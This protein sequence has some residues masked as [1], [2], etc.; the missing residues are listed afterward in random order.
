MWHL[1]III[2]LI[3][4]KYRVTFN[5]QPFTKIY[6]CL[7]CS[8]NRLQYRAQIVRDVLMSVR[9][10]RL[11]RY[12]KQT[13][14]DLTDLAISSRKVLIKVK[15]ITHMYSAL[16]WSLCSIFVNKHYNNKDH[17]EEED[18]WEIVIRMRFGNT[19]LPLF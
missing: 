19:F 2:F 13:L 9:Q 3:W 10:R 18:I 15:I 6:V 5:C 14:R 16:L 17:Q 12:G 7:D 8:D 4:S 1:T 11:Y